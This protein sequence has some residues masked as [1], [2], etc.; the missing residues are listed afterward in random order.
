MQPPCS[1]WPAPSREIS[2]IKSQRS[3]TGTTRVEFLARTPFSVFVPIQV[4]WCPASVTLA[5]LTDLSLY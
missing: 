2:G 1:H 4:G 5:G 3:A